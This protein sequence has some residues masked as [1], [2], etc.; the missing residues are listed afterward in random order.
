M[1]YSFFTLPDIANNHIV[2][3]CYYRSIILEFKPLFY[4]GTFNAT[5]CLMLLWFLTETGIACV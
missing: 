4:F 1:T 5:F 3:Q 2:K